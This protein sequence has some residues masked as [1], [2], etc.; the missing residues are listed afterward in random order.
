MKM[1]LVLTQEETNELKQ[2][3]SVEVKR[4]NVWYVVEVDYVDEEGTHYMITP[5]NPYETVVLK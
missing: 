2:N 1:K 3:G 5:I 4:N